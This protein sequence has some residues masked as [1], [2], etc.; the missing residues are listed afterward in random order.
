[1]NKKFKILTPIAAV[2]VVAAIITSAVFASPQIINKSRLEKLNDPINPFGEPK[3]IELKTDTEKVEKILNSESSDK[4]DINELIK[5]NAISTSNRTSTNN[6]INQPYK[7]NDWFLNTKFWEDLNFDFIGFDEEN[8]QNEDKKKAEKS[9]LDKKAESKNDAWYNNTKFW[10]NLD[11]DFIASDLKSYQTDTKAE[12]EKI[13][14]II[15][16]KEKEIHSVNEKSPEENKIKEKSVDDLEKMLAELEKRLFGSFRD[17]VIAKEKID[18][19]ISD[20]EK[21]KEDN[22]DSKLEEY[23]NKRKDAGEK[24][25]KENDEYFAYKKVIEELQAKLK[26]LSKSKN[27]A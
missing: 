22:N 18:K 2:S 4:S 19:E 7:N 26:K 17:A 23:I 5:N 25:T 6:A 9:K 10:E 13:K 3:N 1:M 14:E 24:L 11:F 21:N 27:S 16:E 8:K 20:L 12:I 15:E